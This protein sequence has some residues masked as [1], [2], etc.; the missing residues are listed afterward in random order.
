MSSILVQPHINQREIDS[1][2]KKDLRYLMVFAM[3]G[4]SP[5]RHIDEIEDLFTA[6]IISK[7]EFRALRNAL[8]KFG[9]WQLDP[10]GYVIVTKQHVDLGDLT[11]HEFTNMT[12]NLLSRA[13]ENGPCYLENL[14]IVTN[15]SLKKE[16]YLTINKTLKTFLQKSQEVEGDR[17]VAWNHIAIDC[18]SPTMIIPP[19]LFS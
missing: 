7:N 17:L 8:L 2:L 19:P 4:I 9:Y 11:L 5:R 16:F 13:S 6:S 3:A 10:L 15:E 14:F 12:L 18:G 1:L